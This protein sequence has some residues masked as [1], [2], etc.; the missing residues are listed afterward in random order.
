MGQQRA[1]D[2]KNN[3]CH[4]KSLHKE[5]AKHHEESECA[6]RIVP[7]PS[8][9]CRASGLTPRIMR[10]HLIITHQKQAV[11]TTD[12]RIKAETKLTWPKCDY[13]LHEVDSAT[14]VS[15]WTNEEDGSFIFWV[16]I[17][18]PKE[19]A[20]KY[21][22]SLQVYKKP[23]VSRALKPS[24]IQYTG[25][26]HCVPLDISHTAM[27]TLKRGIVLD[28]QLIEESGSYQM[29]DDASCLTYSVNITKV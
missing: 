27:K 21:K 25:S 24:D 1:D 5:A 23:N 13:D 19:L 17:I 20:P 8:S 15:N 18:G 3:A 29:G 4:F 22:Y 16:S 2:R 12:P 26:R 11:N 14:F 9:G 6:D 28:K 7:C 10:D